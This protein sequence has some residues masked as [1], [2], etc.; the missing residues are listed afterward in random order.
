MNEPCFH[1]EQIEIWRAIRPHSDSS[2]HGGDDD[3]DDDA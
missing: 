3:D 1:C 2:T